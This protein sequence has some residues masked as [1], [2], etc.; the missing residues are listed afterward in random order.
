MVSL[1]LLLTPN[2]NIEWDNQ[3]CFLKVPEAASKE[4]VELDK[5]VKKEIK[6]TKTKMKCLT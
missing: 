6:G 3:K 5:E 2:L 1:N 4:E